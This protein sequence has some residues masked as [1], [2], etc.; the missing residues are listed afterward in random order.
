MTNLAY[1]RSFVGFDRLFNQ[2]ER[3]AETQ[4]NKPSYPPHNIIKTKNGFILDF[5]VAGY[6]P[7]DLEVSLEQNVLTI[8]TKDNHETM[9]NTFDD[10]V[11]FVHRGISGKS[12]IRKFTIHEYLQIES[13]SYDFGVLHIQLK[14]VIPEEKKPRIF[15]VGYKNKDQKFLTE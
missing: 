10:D 7:D 9:W 1:P 14:E 3:M 12:F 2:I 11:E 6:N 13:V 4:A 5:S 8:K 15:E